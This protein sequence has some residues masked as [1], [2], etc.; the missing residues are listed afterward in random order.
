MFNIASVDRFESL[1]AA[2]VA[3]HGDVVRLFPAVFEEQRRQSEL[4][5]RRS[6]LTEPHHRFFLALLLH[7]VDRSHALDLIRQWDPVVDPAEQ[8]VDWIDELSRTRVAGSSEPNVLGLEM[9]E[10]LI[11]LIEEMLAE[12][13]GWMDAKGQAQHLLDRLHRSPLGTLFAS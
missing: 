7:G 1:L 9:D 13:S 6:T 8:L 10:D 5:R 11:S 3:R 2:A 4:V 12:G